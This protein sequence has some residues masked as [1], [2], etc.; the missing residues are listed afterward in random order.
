MINHDSASSPDS[1]S[2]GSYGSDVN[3][4]YLRGQNQPID[5]DILQE[6]EMKRQKALELQT[7]IKKQ[8]EERERKRKEEKEKK[9]REERAEEERI[10]RQQDLEKQ[11]LNFLINLH[12]NN[13]KIENN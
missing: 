3:K 2:T 13:L 6:R 10:K 8:L 9:I 5:A 1:S 7:A 11:R 4:T 12:A